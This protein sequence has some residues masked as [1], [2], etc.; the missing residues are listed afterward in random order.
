MVH[1]DAEREDLRKVMLQNCKRIM[2]L[3]LLLQQKAQIK[4]NLVAISSPTFHHQQIISPATPQ[5]QYST[6][7]TFDYSFL[8]SAAAHFHYRPPEL[9]PDQAISMTAPSVGAYGDHMAIYPSAQ[10][11][12]DSDA[13]R[14]SVLASEY[15]SHAPHGNTGW[16]SS[17]QQAQLPEMTT[18]TATCTTASA[19][20]ISDNNN[21]IIPTNAVQLPS[22]HSSRSEGSPLHVAADPLCSFP[23]H[24]TSDAMATNGQNIITSPYE[25][26]KFETTLNIPPIKPELA[27]LQNSNLAD[28]SPK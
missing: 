7:R 11:Y 20:S 17:M 6:P 5:V 12:I 26:I 25:E 16:V 23:D 21:M 15:T 1:T 22:P 19:A 18:A 4:Q 10:M 24:E 14:T 9:A 3:I 8:P 27:E 2:F 13:S 28:R